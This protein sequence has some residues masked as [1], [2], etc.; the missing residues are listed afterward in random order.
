MAEN[1]ELKSQLP[2]EEIEKNLFDSLLEILEK[3]QKQAQKQFK[4]HH[5]KALK[6]LKSQGLDPA[7]LKTQIAKY[8]TTGTV[9]IA[10][11]GA[12]AMPIAAASVPVIKTENSESATSLAKKN[13]LFLK[14]KQILDRWGQSPNPTDE[15]LLAQT[16]GEIT[17]LPLTNV[18]E[19]HNL[20]RVVGMIGLEQHLLRYPGDTISAQLP[21]EEDQ[22]YQKAGMAPHVGAWGYFAP[23]KN[24]LTEDLAEKEK[25]YVVIQTFLI[26]GW[27]SNWSGM[28]D[29]YKHRKVLVFNPEN[30]KGVV[31]VIADAGPARWT[32]KHFGG[33]PEV[34]D[35]IGFYGSSERNE[36]VI[37]FLDDPD[38]KIP[39]GPIDSQS[40]YLIARGG[41]K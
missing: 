22:K 40:Y 26:P 9:T 15:N 11:M 32:G 8:I 3:N 27:N 34:M 5:K 18:L 23:S 39:L 12:T 28:K 35:S 24:E 36:V 38:N 2:K 29:W 41:E 31:G 1:S 20:H 37:L 16:I 17:N 19:G 10:I 25:Y 4:R 7:K 13:D 6:W 14:I 21:G 30:G 33:S